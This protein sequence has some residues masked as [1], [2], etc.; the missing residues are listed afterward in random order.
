MQKRFQRLNLP[1]IYSIFVFDFDYIYIEDA[2]K[3][4]GLESELTPAQ[5]NVLTKLRCIMHKQTG[6]WDRMINESQEP[7]ASEG[8]LL[9]LNC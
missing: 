3:K 7:L 2:D 1:Y 6:A 8:R 4:T 5:D 9:D